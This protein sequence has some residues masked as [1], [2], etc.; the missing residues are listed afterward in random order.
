MRMRI[1]FDVKI[2]DK[3]PKVSHK[4]AMPDSQLHGL[5][6]NNHA[7]FKNTLQ[8]YFAERIFLHLEL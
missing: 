1:S 7:V 2:P 8:V 4:E 6:S 5:H 3:T